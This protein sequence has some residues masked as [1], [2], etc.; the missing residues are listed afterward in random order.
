MVETKKHFYARYLCTLA[1][2][3]EIFDTSALLYSFSK[4][5]PCFHIAAA[6]AL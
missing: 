3:H 6:D 5:S 2:Y 1:F 4:L